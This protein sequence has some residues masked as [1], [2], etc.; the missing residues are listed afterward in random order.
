MIGGTVRRMEEMTR[1]AGIGWDDILNWLVDF[2]A[3]AA[4]RLF[5]IAV[6]IVVT[7]VALRLL[8]SMVQRV[9]LRAIESREGTSREAT[10]RATTLAA[11]VEST[12]RYIILF[13]A[14]I[15]IL[16]TLGIS[17]APVLASAGIAGIAVAFG[18]QSLIADTFNGFFILLEGQFA[19]GD[20]VRVGTHEGTVEEL[21]LRRTVLRSTDGAAITI[22]NSQIRTVENLSK[23][24]SRA[25]VE[26]AV[27]PEADEKQVLEVLHEVL[28]GIERDEEL[29]SKI[30]EAPNILGLTSVEPNRLVF[31]A[32]VKTAPMEQWGVA[33]ELQRRIRERF[34]QVGVPLPPRTIDIVSGSPR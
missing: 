23:G 10:Q 17:L 3:N 27:A 29:G 14:I 21:S 33:R 1:V 6:V 25:I 15:T 2:L 5:A 13:I 11:L 32:F 4:S 16:G 26:V 19:V 28:G 34:I 8:R 12:G 24:W 30:L 18:A 22:P 9:F 20:F 7:L 31:R